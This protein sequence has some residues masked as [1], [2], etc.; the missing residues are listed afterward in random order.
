MADKDGSLR[1]GDRLIEVNG[2]DISH[3]EHS[4]IVSLFKSV[5]TSVK[6]VV[7]RKTERDQLAQQKL[8]QKVESYDNLREKY[9]TLEAQ[10]EEINKLKEIITQKET[11]ISDLKRQVKS[12]IILEE[13]EHTALEAEYTY[14]RGY[15]DQLL[16]VL[17]RDAPQILERL[18]QEFDPIPEISESDEPINDEEWC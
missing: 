3:L 18:P 16:T 7:A 14:T 15:L 1:I 12:K 8:A 13:N 11:E 4:A 9:Q 10:I 6:I 2:I 5:T 17:E